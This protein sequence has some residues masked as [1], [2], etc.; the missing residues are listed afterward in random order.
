M[1]VG[2]PDYF[3]HSIFLTYGITKRKVES[4]VVINDGLGKSICLIETKG[5]LLTGY[6]HIYWSNV[7]GNILIQLL[8]DSCF[9]VEFNTA[10]AL[11]SGLWD[12]TEHFFSPFYLNYNEKRFSISF[13]GDITFS[14]TLLIGITNNSG[15]NI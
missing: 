2:Y 14:N 8:A 1:G 15:G 11:T 4:N 6:C 10:T 12:M 7:V 9:A 13:K 5:K 3:G